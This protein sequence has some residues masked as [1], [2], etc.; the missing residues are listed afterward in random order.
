MDKIDLCQKKQCIEQSDDFWSTVY[1]VSF[2]ISSG[3]SSGYMY[4]DV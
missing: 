3:L 2:G 1:L 4:A